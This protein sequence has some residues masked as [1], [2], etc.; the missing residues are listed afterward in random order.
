MMTVMGLVQRDRAKK[1]TLISDAARII[2][3][4]AT[5]IFMGMLLISS[6]F[7]PRGLDGIMAAIPV[8]LKTALWTGVTFCILWSTLWNVKCLLKRDRPCF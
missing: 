6:L 7:L 3:C 8:G 2:L 1:I 5:A 4:Y